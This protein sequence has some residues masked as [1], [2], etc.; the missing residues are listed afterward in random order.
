MAITLKEADEIAA[1]R[2][3]VECDGITYSRITEIGYRYTGKGEK[4][5]FVQLLDKGGRS[6]T[7][8]DP[9]RCNVA[10]DNTQEET[11]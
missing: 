7:Y 9:K 8:A 4:T 3:P 6:V 1:K 2:L 11:Q 10:T 5:S